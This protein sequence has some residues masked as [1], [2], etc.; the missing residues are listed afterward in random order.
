[1]RRLVYAASELSDAVSAFQ[2][3]STTGGLTQL[4][5]TGGCISEFGSPNQ[6]ADGRGL[7]GAR[8]VALSADGKN[9][10]AASALSDAVAILTRE[11]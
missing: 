4:G 11:P 6:C 9:A 3:N 5:G 7:D 10:Y 2:R 1:M 8:S